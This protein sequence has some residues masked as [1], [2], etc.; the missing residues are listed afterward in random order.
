MEEIFSC[1]IAISVCYSIVCFSHP[2]YSKYRKERCKWNI[3]SRYI[4]FTPK[5]YVKIHSMI[6]LHSWFSFL[7]VFFNEIGTI[8]KN[9]IVSLDTNHDLSFQLHGC[10]CTRTLVREH[11]YKPNYPPIKNLVSRG[12]ENRFKIMIFLNDM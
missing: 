9:S 5:I 4:L 3:F 10:N 12:T 1:C 6:V 2:E 11:E 7:N 8:L